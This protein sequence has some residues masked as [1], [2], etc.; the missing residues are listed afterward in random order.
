M[1]GGTRSGRGYGLD[2]AKLV[3]SERVYSWGGWEGDLASRGSP[4]QEGE[5]TRDESATLTLRDVFILPGMVVYMSPEQ[6][7]LVFLRRDTRGSRLH[8]VYLMKY[9]ENGDSYQ[10]DRPLRWVNGLV[11][12]GDLSV[13][14][15]G[16]ELVV[17]QYGS[18]LDH[19][20]LFENMIA[21]AERKLS[22]QK[23]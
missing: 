22:A 8:H 14:P 23:E 4:H 7:E 6:N 11:H 12:R 18:R 1:A 3:P 5:L 17:R 19:V 20:V 13:H 10:F 15:Q 21:A 9:R 2:E 16:Q